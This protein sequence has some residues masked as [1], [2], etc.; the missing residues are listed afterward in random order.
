MFIEPRLKAVRNASV[1]DRFGIIG[2]YINEVV[3][4]DARWFDLKIDRLGWWIE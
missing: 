3:V 2:D 1:E 4:H